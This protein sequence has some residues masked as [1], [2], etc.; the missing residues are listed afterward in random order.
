MLVSFTLYSCINY[1]SIMRHSTINCSLSEESVKDLLQKPTLVQR[2][3][4]WKPLW[5]RNCIL[6]E[7]LHGVHVLREAVV[8]KWTPLTVEYHCLLIISWQHFTC[9]CTVCTVK[10]TTGVLLHTYKCVTS[11]I[12][13]H[14]MHEG[15]ILCYII[16]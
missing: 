7:C 9:F 5:I 3:F 2:G 6:H 4:Q 11:S 10:K 15:F 8:M 16:Q 13:L 14:S 12:I 1:Y